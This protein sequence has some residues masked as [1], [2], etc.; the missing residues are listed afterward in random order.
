[1][2]FRSIWPI[3]ICLEGRKTSRRASGESQTVDIQGQTDKES[4]KDSRF[5]AKDGSLRKNLANDGFLRRQGEMSEVGQ[6]R[7]QTTLID[8]LDIHKTS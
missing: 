2:P 6:Q 4:K 5:T 8:I 3:R 7:Y 1:M